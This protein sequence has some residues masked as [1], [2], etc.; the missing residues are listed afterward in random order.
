MDYRI[1][2][3]FRL[4]PTS[5]GRTR[6]LL[7]LEL[8]GVPPWT[9]RLIAHRVANGAWLVPEYVAFRRSPSALPHIR[10]VAKN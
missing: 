7:T 10:I 2:G 6:V 9:I 1:R 5:P 8:L 3:S 4:T